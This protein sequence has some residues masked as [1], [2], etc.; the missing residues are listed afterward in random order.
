MIAGISHRSFRSK[1]CV[2]AASENALIPPLLMTRASTGDTTRV[3]S[4][5]LEITHQQSARY[6][7]AASAPPPLALVPMP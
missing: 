6:V 2:P 5:T 7:G 1:D 4:A 3:C